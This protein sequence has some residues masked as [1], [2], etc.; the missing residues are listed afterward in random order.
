MRPVVLLLCGGCALLH[1]QPLGYSITDLAKGTNQFGIAYALNAHGEVVGDANFHAFVW[2]KG[3][4]QV[5]PPLANGFSTARGINDL[6]QVVGSAAPK[7]EAGPFLLESGVVTILPTPGGTTYNVAV[8]INNQGQILV[9]SRGASAGAFIWEHGVERPIPSPGANLVPTGLNQQGQV[10]GYRWRSG[11]FLGHAFLFSGG[12]VTD[13][14]V[15][16]GGETL[17]DCNFCAVGNF[18][19]ATAINDLGEVV[20]Q[21]AAAGPV[22][23]AFL[24][25]GG[26]ME[27]LGTLAGDN[28]S[29]ASS[30]NDRGQIVGWSGHTSGA[31]IDYTRAVLWDKGSAVDLN[32]LI[33]PG[34]G[35][36]L[37]SAVAINASGQIAGNGHRDGLAR[38]FLLTPVRGR[39]TS[40]CSGRIQ[41]FGCDLSH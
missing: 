5:P 9:D 34:S 10:V 3:A 31:I 12:G 7:G 32:D 11:T 6:G 14:G 4:L 8:A 29:Y 1:A 37:D 17:P 16:P 41:R 35:W 22:L 15:L 38:P 23:H 26:A 27:D 40:G 30:I 36:T 39:S 21:A 28:R 13:L 19:I 2:S 18:S 33:P 24:W 25:R 20:G